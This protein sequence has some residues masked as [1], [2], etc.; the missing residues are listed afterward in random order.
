MNSFILIGYIDYELF[1]SRDCSFPDISCDESET[2][3]D[4][5]KTIPLTELI[6]ATGHRDE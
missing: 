5:M 1:S 2:T 4:T 6:E 3:N